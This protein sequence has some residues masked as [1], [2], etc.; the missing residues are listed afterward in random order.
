MGDVAQRAQSGADAFQD[1]ASKLKAVS[2]R[3]ETQGIV[4]H[5]ILAK[6]AAEH[7]ERA[8]AYR[9]IATM[10]ERPIGSLEMELVEWDALKLVKVRGGC[11]KL[12]CRTNQGF[13]A[14]K[15]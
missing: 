9:E 8:N 2:S 4:G 1:S 10:L 6:L 5:S 12:Q 7:E 13:D 14:I 11:D 15:S 3:Q